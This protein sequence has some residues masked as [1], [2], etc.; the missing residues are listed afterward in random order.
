MKDQGEN[1]RCFRV[2][3][4]AWSIEEQIELRDLFRKFKEEQD[5]NI[6]SMNKMNEKLMFSS[7]FDFV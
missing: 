4:G 2:K 5:E 6:G 3:S 7:F 1:E